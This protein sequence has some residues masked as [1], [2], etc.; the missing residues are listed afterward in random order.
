M[1]IFAK[2]GLSILYS[3]IYLLLVDST[4]TV[5]IIIIRP[6]VQIKK[7]CSL[8]VLSNFP[9]ALSPKDLELGF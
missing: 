5:A 6:I 9:K 1:E 2:F 7:Y 3:F 8:V 4:Y